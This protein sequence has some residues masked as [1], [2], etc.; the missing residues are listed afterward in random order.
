MG[1]L[2]SWPPCLAP[3]IQRERPASA[4]TRALRS[5]VKGASNYEVDNLASDTPSSV[6]EAIALRSG[7]ACAYDGGFG[8]PEAKVMMRAGGSGSKA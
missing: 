4:K 7:S 2:P 5:L 3:N 6:R 8:R 1:L